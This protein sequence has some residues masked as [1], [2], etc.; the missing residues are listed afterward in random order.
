MNSD[1]T[2][3]EEK[4][5]KILVDENNIWKTESQLFTWL[6]GGIRGI[7]KKHPMKLNYIK[8]SL[9]LVENDNPRSMKRFPMIKKGRCSICNEVFSQK[10][11]EVDHIHGGNNKITSTEDVEDF[12]LNIL[13]VETKD[14]RIVCKPCHKTLSYQA[15]QGIKSFEKAWVEKEVI[16]LIKEKDYSLFKEYGLDIPKNDK[17][18]RKGIRGLLYTKKGLT[19]GL[20]D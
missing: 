10:D 14:L 6:R 4:I 3:W 1:R 15:K 8:N 7:W 9:F 17:E 12:I 18:R 11:L 2:H 20:Y 16:A 13:F 5:K 19:G